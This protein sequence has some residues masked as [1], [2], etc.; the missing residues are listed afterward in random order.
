MDG[1]Q[2]PATGF[3]RLAVTLARHPVIGTAL[4]ILIIGGSLL[5]LSHTSDTDG[6]GRMEEA[7]NLMV[8]ANATVHQLQRE[9]GLSRA[10]TAG[11]QSLGARLADQL[12]A[13]DSSRRDLAMLVKTVLHDLPEETRN[14][15]ETVQTALKSVDAARGRIRSGQMG[16]SDVMLPYSTAIESLIRLEASMQ[17]LAETTAVSGGMTALLRIVRVKEASGQER[18]VGASALAHGEVTAEQRQR[19]WDLTLQ[20]TRSL[21]DFSLWATEAQATFLRQAMADPAMSEIENDRQILQ[22]SDHPS[23][24][25]QAWFDVATAR[26]DRFNWLEDQL[27]EDIRR[28]AIE[29]DRKKRARG[30]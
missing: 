29:A 3:W 21:A 7:A 12:S 17:R 24:T 25:A 23:L 28:T 8:Q 26:I 1:Y 27:V 16:E 30:R 10:L 18:A 19:L 2:Q 5:G 9:R 6:L 13:T 22:N 15:W 20:Q 4:P 14:R 11:D